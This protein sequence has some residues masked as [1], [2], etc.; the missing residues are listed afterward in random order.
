MGASPP[1]VQGQPTTCI[2]SNSQVLLL[3]S[4]AHWLAMPCA[5]E[6]GLSRRAVAAAAPGAPA[7]GK[8]CM[9]TCASACMRAAA[10]R[11]VKQHGAVGGGARAGVGVDLLRAQRAAHV[12]VV[13]LHGVQRAL[14]RGAQRHA[15]LVALQLRSRRAPCISAD[16]R[17]TRLRL[18]P[19]LEV[20]GERIA[21]AAVGSAACIPLKDGS[22]SLGPLRLTS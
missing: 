15:V 8:Q 7:A 2:L 3:I 16:R 1:K 14:A 19:R 10:A 12:V 17:Q 18:A 4:Q 13:A 5:I 22:L 20:P 11:T 9:R 21:Q 6:A